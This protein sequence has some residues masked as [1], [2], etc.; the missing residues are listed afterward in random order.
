M[1][2]TNQVLPCIFP[3]SVFHSFILCLYNELRTNEFAT[4]QDTCI[5][6]DTNDKGTAKHHDSRNVIAMHLDIAILTPDYIIYN[7]NYA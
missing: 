1:A 4:P 7:G 6:L 2:N 5:S 3:K